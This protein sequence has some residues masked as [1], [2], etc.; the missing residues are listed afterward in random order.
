MCHW[1]GA[2][3][4]AQKELKISRTADGGAR[5][6]QR[7]GGGGG[8]EWRGKQNISDMLTLFCTDKERDF[9][10]R[11][12]NVIHEKRGLSLEKNPTNCSEECADH[13]VRCNINDSNR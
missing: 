2:V 6:K 7:R 13:L 3:H 8:G 1:V 11:H 12:S 4:P 9:T 5:E 10:P